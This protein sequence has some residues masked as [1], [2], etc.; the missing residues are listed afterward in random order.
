MSEIFRRLE[1]QLPPRH[2]PT[3]NSFATDPKMLR[4]WIDHLPWA[5]PTA[6]TRMLLSGLREMNQL[7][8][9]ATQRITA[10]EMLR[11]P[12]DR[13]VGALEKQTLGDS[14][15][16]PPQKQQWGAVAQDF[17]REFAIGYTA[18]L[19]DLCAPAGA[20]PFMRGK[21]VALALTR[22]IQHLGARLYRAY[23]LYQVPPAGVWRM[24]HDLF[25]FGAA[26]RYDEKT[27][28]DP[29][30]GS[31]QISARHAYMHALLL[32]LSNPYHFTQRENATMYALTRICAIHCDLRPGPAPTGAVAVHVDSDS[33]PGYLPEEREIPSDGVWAFRVSGLIRF[34]D[35][36]LGMLPPG[37]VMANFRLKGGS[38]MQIDTKLIE[39]LMHLWGGN[40]ERQFARLAANHELETVTGLHDT[41]YVLCGNVDFDSFLRSTRGAGAISLSEGDT[42][43]AWA[44][45]REQTRVFRR[46]AKVLDQS[47]GG[48]R[49]MWEKTESMR[50]KVGEMLALA[51]SAE[52]GDVQEWMVGVIRWLRVETSGA[53]EAGVELLSRRAQGVGVRSVAGDGTLGPAMRGVMLE[54]LSFRPTPD[55]APAPAHTILAPN[56]FDHNATEIELTRSADPLMWPPGPTIVT[57][58]QVRVLDHGGGYVQIALDQPAIADDSEGGDDVLP[59]ANDDHHAA[60]SASA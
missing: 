1:G 37:S 27:S 6:T 20:V 60:S 7:R 5:N 18:S 3:R 14:F 52:D 39:R 11:A 4:D 13:I 41:H 44:T 45:S 40:A 46:I 22:A 47:L 49:V 53:M 16:L 48:Y 31:V 38:P 51:S 23:L 26:V 2:E 10:L 29:L 30:I 55:G 32:A 50:A 15:P 34:L 43:A 42:V 21:S 36:E 33:S 9:D 25:R 57:L 8:F 35:G 28:S 54:P 12:V 17:E 56:L 19:C 58:R 24:L 59:A